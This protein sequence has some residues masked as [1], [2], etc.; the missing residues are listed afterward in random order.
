MQFNSNG[1]C[2]L[3]TAS[4]LHQLWF[5]C[6]QCVIRVQRHSELPASNT[7]HT[8]LLF[9]DFRFQSKARIELGSEFNL[10]GPAMFHSTALERG[11]KIRLGLTAIPLQYSAYSA[12]MC[13][14]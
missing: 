10:K 13:L 7:S 8:A 6:L 2:N 3:F 9:S 4:S 11:R 5:E 1:G 12:S 14:Q